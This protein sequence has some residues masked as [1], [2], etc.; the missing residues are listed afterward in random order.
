[1][2]GSVLVGFHG[3]GQPKLNIS[4]CEILNRNQPKW[5]ETNR[6]RFISVLV[7]FGRFSILVGF[8]RFSVFQREGY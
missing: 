4:V 8:D 1:M 5:L 2:L 3:Y 7:G 6:F